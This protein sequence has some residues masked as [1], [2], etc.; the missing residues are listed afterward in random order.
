MNLRQRVLVATLAVVALANVTTLLYFLDREREA[1]V[2]LLHARVA[3]DTQLLSV[4]TAGPLYDGNL[5][6][7]NV[8]LDMLF[9]NPDV[10]T[11]RLDEAR[12]DIALR[13][14]RP[15]AA[16]RG[17]HIDRAAPVR[18][19][20]DT[21]G[22]VQLSYSTASIE[23]R[24]A[25]SRNAM[26]A[27]SLVLM[28]VLGLL[29]YALARQLT[30]P[31]EQLTDA[32]RAMAGGDLQRDVVAEGAPELHVLGESFI[33]LRDAVR[34]KVTELEA[35]N[36]RLSL[37]VQERTRAEQEALRLIGE[38]RSV[39]QAIHDILYMVD[40][41]AR[42]VWWN[43]RAEEVLA[44]DAQ[45]LRGTPALQYFV[46]SDRARVALAL[47]RALE[48]GYS[49]IEARLVTANGEAMYRFN[50][51]RIT[52][53]QGQLVGVAGVGSD[54]TERKAAEAAL[55]T[56]ERR[57]RALVD[58]TSDWYWQ[59]DA[60]HRFVVLEG[61]ILRRM[62]LPPAQ[63]YGRTVWEL[64]DVVNMSPADWARHR[65]QVERRE[66][67]RDLLVGRTGA[68]GVVY[69]AMLSGQ[70]LFDDTGAFVGYHGTGRDITA[71]VTAEQALRAS[72]ARI[73]AAYSTLN[74]AINSAPAAI[75]VFDAED[76]LIA[77]NAHLTDL[78][79][80]SLVEVREGITFRDLVAGFSA[81]GAVASPARAQTEWLE[82][83][84][85]QHRNPGAP[86]EI[87][88]T[89]GRWLQV[90]ETRTSQGGIVTVYNDITTLKAR[91][92]ELRRLAD[93]LE[94]RVSTR[95]AELA[96][97]NR[98]LE[99]FASTV[100]HDLRAPLR[101]IDGFGKMLDDRLAANEDAESR[102]HVQRMRKAAQRMGSIIDELLKFS[103][104][105]RSE[106]HCRWVEMS[107]VAR[108]VADELQRSAPERQ[109]RW[110]I[111]PELRAW[112][113]LG[114]IHLVLDNLL[115]NAWKYT[116]RKQQ[117]HIEFGVE[118]T[119]DGTREFFVRDDGAGF[120]MMHA[121]MLFQPFRRLHGQHEFEGTGIGLAS[122][123]R[124]IERHGGSIRGEGEVGQGATFR[125]TLPQP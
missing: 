46:E 78:V 88:L 3:E 86:I 41:Q 62:G 106:L 30:Q 16:G 2:A 57:F 72:E 10:V 14:D 125:F 69:W 23:R 50:G 67:F 33:S 116:G 7:L 99:S 44:M 90:T 36:R 91:E 84:C 29:A 20:P 25:E 6:E 77:F 60:E 71:Q 108:A 13:R 114:L 117:A 68:D 39:T 12:G 37:E 110:S 52:D 55:R 81:G 21:L 9:S 85:R 124:I 121:A 38:H 92:T 83:R 56:S 22:S 43:R 53:D 97:A 101:G 59:T 115:G 32:A 58:M 28:A 26:V 104:I 103:R 111:T 54:I 47:D 112:A 105:G 45:A 51:V 93:E 75:A 74:D 5:A 98:E 94:S 123:K 122:V 113:D 119:A 31:I 66:E 15:T 76:R 100:A 1:A 19:G 65:S 95:T 102:N 8:I 70:A 64:S 87:G 120:N 79:P 4:V 118:D 17:E 48:Q 35:A 61:E 42:L 27:L 96:A 80:G 107:Q 34:Q 63:D 18:R 89:D 109:V 82:E 49:E 40:I 73:T 11:V 24:L